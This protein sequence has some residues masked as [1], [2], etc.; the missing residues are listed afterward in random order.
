M[1]A[2][3]L[4]AVLRAGLRL[5]AEAP[6]RF[7]AEATGKCRLGPS[8]KL[9][10]TALVEQGEDEVPVS[11][12]KEVTVASIKSGNTKRGSFQLVK[13]AQT[14]EGVTYEAKANNK[15]Y[16]A[17]TGQNNTTAQFLAQIT[18]VTFTA[19]NTVTFDI[20]L[21]ADKSVKKFAYR[22]APGKN[23][24][25]EISAFT[26]NREVPGLPD[27]FWPQWKDELP[28]LARDIARAAT[29]AGCRAGGKCDYG[30][31]L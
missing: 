27:G 4:D 15:I 25:I 23:A 8:A 19:G 16:S 6:E 20:K 31:A 11:W 14:E 3:S 5:Q 24:C 12:L 9:P 13:A 22:Y 10:S 2:S 1:A 26:L 30:L 28:R 7:E 17:M 21:Q 18:L 29:S